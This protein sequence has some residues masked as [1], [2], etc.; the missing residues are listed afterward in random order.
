MFP[1]QAELSPTR[2]RNWRLWVLLA[3]VAAVIVTGFLLPPIPQSQDYHNFAD[4]RKFL[5]VPNFL[6]VASN[7]LFLVF[8]F[9]GIA[10]VFSRMKRAG[11]RA[12]AFINPG[13]AWSYLIFFCAVALTAFGS[14]YYHLAPN[15]QTLLWDRIPMA[16]GFMA[17]LA[18]LISERISPKVGLALLLPLLAIGAGSVVFWEIS[19][20]AGHG[21]LR[22][23]ALV[24]FGSLLLLLLILALF[25]PR[26]TRGADLILALALYAS[27]KIFEA[28]DRPIFSAGHIV[29]GHTLKHI[30]AALATYA[31]YKMLRNRR[32]VAAS[33]VRNPGHP[34]QS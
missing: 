27:A 9:M 1:A 5:G 14:A 18:A 11:A 3:T 28:A 8:G 13:E 32:P 10:L 25:P 20:R 17:L 2:A 26:Y 24:Q 33:P 34:S 23:Y 19:Q 30:V 12:F 7:A 6:N 4:Q 31:I 15:D 21:D 22:P 29:S 16:I